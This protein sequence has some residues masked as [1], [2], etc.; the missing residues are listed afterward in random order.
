MRKWSAVVFVLKWPVDVYDAG[1][2]LDEYVD[3][4]VAEITPEEMD[5]RTW[6][7]ALKNRIQH[8]AELGNE[9]RLKDLRDSL[10]S[11]RMTLADADAVTSKSYGSVED[12]EKE[13]SKYLSGRD[14]EAAVNSFLLYPVVERVAVVEDIGVDTREEA[15]EY[16]AWFVLGRPYSPRPHEKYGKIE[17]VYV[18]AFPHF[19]R[20]I[21][22][23]IEKP[24]D[25]GLVVLTVLGVVTAGG[26]IYC[27]ARRQT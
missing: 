21:D 19:S 20:I 17:V 4:S 26:I 24:V 25:L 22:P 6:L 13:L 12:L 1:T 27:L 10:T 23:P 15:E 3:H 16:A 18:Y 5:S 2:F 9:L 7:K 11:L 14:L 8:H